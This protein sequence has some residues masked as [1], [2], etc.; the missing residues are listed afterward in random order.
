VLL[1]RVLRQEREALG[2]LINAA[3][4]SLDLDPVQGSGRGRLISWYLSEEIKGVE[5][6][7]GWEQLGH[8]LIDDVMVIGA[9]I[10]D[11]LDALDICLTAEVPLQ[12]SIVTLG[13]AIFEPT[14]RLCYLLDSSVT[15]PQHLL[16]A[17]AHWVDKF[18]STENSALTNAHD[19]EERAA[20]V[21]RTDQMHKDLA[22][23]GITRLPDRKNP[24]LTTNVTLQGEVANVRF[25][26]TEAAKRYLSG[27]D[28]AWPLLSGAAH[29]KSWYINSSYGFE[30]EDNSAITKPEETH[31]FV[32]L[33]LLS[34]SDALVDTLCSWTG[35]DPDPTHKKTHLRRIAVTQGMTTDILTFKTFAEYSRSFEADNPGARREGSDPTSE[36]NA[37]VP[38]FAPR[39]APE[40]VKPQ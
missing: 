18:E 35:L 24:R 30:G 36:A 32:L 10:R 8:A 3:H 26:V 37:A 9:G 38:S 40:I 16:R 5:H 6:A 20:I 27:V 39:K 4:S 1:R 13:R 14:V 25:N 17:A 15:P 34:A 2:V 11:H 31:S 23:I 7:G 33:L 21:S 19:P 28:F 22:A 29:S 12:T